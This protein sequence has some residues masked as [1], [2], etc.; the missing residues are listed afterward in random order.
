MSRKLKKAIDIA[1]FWDEE[2]NPVLEIV[3]KNRSVDSY[4]EEEQEEIILRG[5]FP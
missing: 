4:S 3:P 5:F 1:D 2:M